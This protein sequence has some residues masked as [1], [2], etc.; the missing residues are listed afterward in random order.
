MT[1]HSNIQTLTGRSVLVIGG[2]S[3]IGLSVAL[4]AQ[5]EGAQVTI[6]GSDEARAR[7][8]ASDH[9]F[10]GWRAADVGQPEAMIKALADVEKVDHLVML[11]GSFV[12]G[13]VLETDIDAL[14]G[15][16]DQ[17]LWAAI[18]V[19][20]ALGDRLAPDASI[21]LTSGAL[22]DRPN[23][24]GT[25]IMAAACAALESLARAMALEL[26]PRRFNAVAPGPTDTPLLDRALG[27]A[28]D[29]YVAALAG[30]LPLGRIGTADDVASAI[31]FLMSHGWMTGETLH[32]DG[33][34]RLV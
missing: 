23:A 16:F 34:A 21:T 17:R 12:M 29:D 10:A 2:T 28:K 33:G 14:R 3:G 1:L 9:G 30:S 4:Q 6:L 7:Q 18:H 20:R 31:T 8:V 13:G 5:A 15:V 24:H 25:A 11:A 26:A 19:L 22:A 32:V 27:P